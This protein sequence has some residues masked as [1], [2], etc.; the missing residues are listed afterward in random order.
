[1]SDSEQL[2][3]QGDRNVKLKAFSLEF[4]SLYCFCIGK[5]TE[6]SLRSNLL[7]T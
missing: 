2:L 3:M 6:V 5:F 4:F 1:M 7:E